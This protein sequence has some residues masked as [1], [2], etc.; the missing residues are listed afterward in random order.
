M[1]FKILKFILYYCKKHPE[2]YNEL[3]DLSTFMEEHQKEYDNWYFSEN[4]ISKLSN[5]LKNKD[6]K[7]FNENDI[8][9]LFSENDELTQIRDIINQNGLISFKD[10]ELNKPHNF[11]E[12]SNLSKDTTDK[13]ILKYGAKKGGI[14][15]GEDFLKIILKESVE[16][17]DHGDIK[18]D[19]D[20]ELKN[21]EVKSANSTILV[22]GGANINT[23]SEYL[24]EHLFKSKD[25]NIINYFAY[26]YTCKRLLER[27]NENKISLKSF[28]ECLFDA[29]TIQYKYK[30]FDKEEKERII[31]K[32]LEIDY[33]LEG[34]VGNYS[35][36]LTYPLADY[37]GLMQLYLYVNFLSIDYICIF[38]PYT[39][40]YIIYD[41]NTINNFEN[42][43]YLF[44]TGG[45][46]E[47]G[48]GRSHATQE[49]TAGI[50]FNDKY[51][52]ANL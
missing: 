45:G 39:M 21:L 8:L 18:L 5:V 37:L 27:I 14:G 9:K 4:D 30:S 2:A 11:Y 13:L 1:N 28:L 12:L 42:M 24:D 3:Q 38:S 40:N 17:K 36:K 34:E 25:E 35:T 51:F 46:G 47:K 50:F 31:K 10:I 32:L 15:K 44:F 48:N 22:I 20:G 26:S 41:R 43:R 16:H 7:L 52:K 49:W 29:A 23:L 33:L 6:V 19:I